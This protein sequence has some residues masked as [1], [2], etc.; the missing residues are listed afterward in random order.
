GGSARG[1]G[2]CLRAACARVENPIERCA[3]NRQFSL[4][5][6]PDNTRVPAGIGRYRSA[7][8]VTVS[9]AS[10]DRVLPSWSTGSSPLAGPFADGGDACH[11]LSVYTSS[12]WV[13]R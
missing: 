10:Y 6:N 12:T 3:S 7:Y 2:Y 13:R 8:V 4:S 1:A 9:W 11:P 5:G